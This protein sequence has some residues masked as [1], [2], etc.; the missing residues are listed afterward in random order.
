MIAWLLA[1]FPVKNRDKKQSVIVTDLK[2][3]C[4]YTELID[5]I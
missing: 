4:S 2:Q 3:I 5:G 1:Y